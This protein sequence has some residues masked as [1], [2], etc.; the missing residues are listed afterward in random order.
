MLFYLSTFNIST[1]SF[2][3]DVISLIIKVTMALAREN[4]TRIIVRTALY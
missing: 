4:K 2:S 1:S 3:A